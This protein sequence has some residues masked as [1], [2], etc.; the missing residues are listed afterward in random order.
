MDSSTH[1]T[2]SSKWSRQIELGELYR[3][4]TFW[5]RFHT[6]IPS[7]RANPD[8]SSRLITKFFVFLFCFCTQH[9]L[10]SFFLERKKLK[11]SYFLFFYYLVFNLVFLCFLLIS[12]VRDDGKATT[13]S[14]SYFIIFLKN[15]YT[16]TKRK[17]SYW[18]IRF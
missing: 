1:R 10:I 2:K 14:Y 17:K 11:T 4:G 15:W 18:L 8:F 16:W 6:R 13:S 9:I 12:I 3:M 5:T 7:E